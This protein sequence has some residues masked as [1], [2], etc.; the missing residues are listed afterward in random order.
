[1]KDTIKF[2]QPAVSG[3]ALGLLAATTADIA[4][5]LELGALTLTNL[6]YFALTLHDVGCEPAKTPAVASDGLEAPA[7]DYL[8]GAP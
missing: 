4:H 8:M 6:F 7:S 3:V 5:A 2:L 1:M